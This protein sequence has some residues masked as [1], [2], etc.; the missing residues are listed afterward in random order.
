MSTDFHLPDV[1]EG[2]AD[3]EIVRWLAQPGEAVT[4]DEPFVDIETD[5]AVVSITAPL[6]GTLLSHGGKEGDVLA[7]GALLAVFEGAQAS[8]ADDI[9]AAPERA[10]RPE[11]GAGPSAGTPTAPPAATGR[12]AKATPSTRRLARE[13]GVDIANVRGTGPGGRVSDSDVESASHTPEHSEP[14]G[15]EATAPAQ[16]TSPK[17]IPLPTAARPLATADERIPIRGIRRAVARTMTESWSTIPHVNSF[18][19]IDLFDLQRLRASLK[20]DGFGIP[21]TAFLVRAVALALREY[22]VLNSEV[23]EAS[24]EI[25][26]RHHRN[27]GVAID[28]P[29]GLMVPVIEDADLR[30]LQEIGVE[31]AELAAGALDRRLPQDK[32]RGGTFT[33]NNYGPLGGWFGTSLIKPPEVGILSIGPARD[34]VVARSEGIVVRPMAMLSLAA[35][36]R[37]ADGREIIGFVGA[38]KR[39]LQSPASMLIEG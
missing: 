16:R 21:L 30:S 20:A 1:G 3:A 34:T 28:T 5:K 7:V 31:L 4:Q 38:V 12:K 2:L 22:P 35:D 10:A 32:L 13:L 17:A 18:D 15:R 19:E 14:R 25:I 37:V 6:S 36:H 9:D 29:D 26:L 33:V 39:R 24:Q 23:N 11:P 27:I 8:G